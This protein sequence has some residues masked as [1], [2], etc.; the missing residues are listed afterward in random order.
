MKKIAFSKRL[1]PDCH[2][3]NS[4]GWGASGVAAEHKFYGIMIQIKRDRHEKRS[5]ERSRVYEIIK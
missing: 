2:Y 1:P 5:G 3:G 4:K